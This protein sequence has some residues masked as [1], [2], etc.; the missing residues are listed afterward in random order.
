MEDIGDAKYFGGFQNG[1]AIE[2]EALGIV[3][4]VA[5]RS[6]V[7]RI[8]IIERRII[9]KVELDT[10]L[11]AA[12]EYRTETLMVIERNGDAGNH[13]RWVL[14]MSLPVKRQVHCYPMAEFGE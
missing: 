10:V 13:G 3:I 7:E 12:I 8:A 6:A 11:L 4:V 14:E 1:A 5:E 2:C 9:D